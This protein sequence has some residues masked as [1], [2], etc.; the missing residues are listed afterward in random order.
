MGARKE[1]ATTG[2][3]GMGS[4]KDSCFGIGAMTQLTRVESCIGMNH[5]D[6]VSV[7]SR[8][9]IEGMSRVDSGAENLQVSLRREGEEKRKGE[10]RVREG[11]GG[12]LRRGK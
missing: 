7:M 9:D 2:G 1:S 6:S 5:K 12:H 3:Q 10:G 4:K 8:L 11:E